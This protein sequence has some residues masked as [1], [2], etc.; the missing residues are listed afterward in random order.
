MRGRKR[1]ID[2]PELIIPITAHAAFEKACI[3]FKI[4]CIKIP[5]NK[6]DYK[7]NLKLVEKKYIKKYNMS[8]W[9][10]PKF[11]SLYMR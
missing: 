7:V 10:I 9:F 1:G 4:K 2:N 6:T 8:S 11:P 5:L 3:M